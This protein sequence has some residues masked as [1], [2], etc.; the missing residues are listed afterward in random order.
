MV[1]YLDYV[2][3]AAEFPTY[4][5]ANRPCTEVYGHAPTCVGPIPAVNHQGLFHLMVS[6]SRSLQSQ[7]TVTIHSFSILQWVN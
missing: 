2:P 3:D 6:L 4:T 5:S 7:N 1:L